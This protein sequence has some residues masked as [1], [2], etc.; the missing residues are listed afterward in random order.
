MRMRATYSGQNGPNLSRRRSSKAA[1][2]RKGCAVSHLPLVRLLWPIRISDEAEEGRRKD[3]DERPRGSKHKRPPGL[4]RAG[5][6]A[7]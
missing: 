6:D 4:Q 5:L 2:K 3:A 7:V 1:K